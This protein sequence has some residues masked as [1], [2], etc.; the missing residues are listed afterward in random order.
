MGSIHLKLRWGNNGEHAYDLSVT[1]FHPKK[2]HR[3]RTEESGKL[4]D[5]LTAFE[6]GHFRQAHFLLPFIPR[7]D[8]SGTK[9]GTNTV[10]HDSMPAHRCFGGFCHR[11]CHGSPWIADGAA[12]RFIELQTM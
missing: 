8:T 12:C 6:F 3:T 1:L 7:L 11:G 10:I 9:K 4:P 2:T 5:K